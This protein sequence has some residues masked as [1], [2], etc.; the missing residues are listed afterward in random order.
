[1]KVIFLVLLILSSWVYAAIL[2]TNDCAF[3]IHSTS[4]SRVI[5]LERPAILPATLSPLGHKFQTL[6][7]TPNTPN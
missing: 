2:G 6:P 3:M 5:A 4:A 7:Q 1:M